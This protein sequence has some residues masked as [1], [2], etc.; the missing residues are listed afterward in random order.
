MTNEEKFWFLISEDNINIKDLTILIPELKLLELC[1][2]N[3]P[4][5][6][7]NVLEHSIETM[8]L[9][10]NPILRAVALLH[11]IGKY[12]AV[13]YDESGITRYKGHDKIS[14]TLSSLIFRS[15]G[16]D[17]DKVNLLTILIYYHDTPMDTEEKIIDFKN[18]YG[19]ET[20]K[21][22]YE[23]QVCDM[24]THA[25]RYA[26]MKLASLFDIQKTY[27]YLLK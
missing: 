9:T 24:S 8:K 17:E 19:L 15:I 25:P 20:L 3:H 21:L 5:H 26:S 18:R 23:F 7:Y 1:P 11:D 13:T 2:V 4:A 12:E 6:I 27:S 22:L 14:A 16:V 10:N